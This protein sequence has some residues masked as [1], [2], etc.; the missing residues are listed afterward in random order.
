MM[1][2][3]IALA[4]TGATC[5]AETSR[6]I[7]FRDTVAIETSELL[8]GDAA[9]LSILPGRLRAQ[10]STVT[11]LK[12]DARRKRVAKA[13]LAKR[14]QA[15]VP[16]LRCWIDAQRGRVTVA[17]ASRAAVRP[18]PVPEPKD[19]TI[20]RGRHLALVANVGPVRVTRDV[21]ALQSAGPG[22]RLFVRDA[23][24]QI[25]STRYI[26]PAR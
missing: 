17:R 9:D 1:A 16:L 20:A 5:P 4:A 3:T 15:M 11:L 23:D 21:E 2:A 10:A 13:L 25:L 12:V 18:R 7:A 22:E 6:H 24:G 19:D 26:E 8:L 14:A